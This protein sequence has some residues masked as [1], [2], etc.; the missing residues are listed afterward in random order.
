M[1]DITL[2]DG[3]PWWAV[4]LVALVY[5]MWRFFEW[6]T[7]RI[8]KKQ[9]ALLEQQEI[10]Q[11]AEL[12][13]L[14]KA[15]QYDREQEKF[16]LEWQQKNQEVLNSA[17]TD[18]K[19]E[20]SRT[21]VALMGV[22]QNTTDVQRQV[23]NLSM[24]ITTMLNLLNQQLPS[25]EQMIK[26]LE[27]INNDISRLESDTISNQ[28]SLDSAHGYLRALMKKLEDELGVSIYPDTQESSSVTQR[29]FSENS[30]PNR[31][32]SRT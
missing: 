25:V 28:H 2:P 18:L 9:A 29:L 24:G 31:R 16:W 17:I 12:E 23:T 15:E 7:E 27:R 14:N 4:F 13:R 20:L 1:T 21:N 3:S 30:P 19:D 8:A 32:Q 10:K 6:A 11:K 5:I 26:L 22:V